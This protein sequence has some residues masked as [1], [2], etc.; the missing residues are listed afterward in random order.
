[1]TSSDTVVLPLW[2]DLYIYEGTQQ[3]IYYEIGGTAPSRTVIFEYYLSHYADDSQ[4]YHFLVYFYEAQ[5]NVVTF[6][7]LNVSDLGVSATVGVE[8]DTAGNYAQYSFDQAIIY[9]GLQITYDPSSNT[10]VVDDAGD[11]SSSAT[12]D[13]DSQTFEEIG[14]KIQPGSQQG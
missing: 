4:Y 2:D 5:A 14:R 11:S 1:M 8:S 7:Y 3:G 6:Q 13:D 12:V 10:W 9:P